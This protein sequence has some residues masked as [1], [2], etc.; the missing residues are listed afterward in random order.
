MTKNNNTMI[1]VSG[2][3]NAS[4]LIKPDTRTK[5]TLPHVPNTISIPRIFQSARDKETKHKPHK[6]LPDHTHRLVGQKTNTPPHEGVLYVGY[7]QHLLYDKPRP[8]N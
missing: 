1:A 2:V 5:N 6:R 3:T 8:R 4:T 7:S